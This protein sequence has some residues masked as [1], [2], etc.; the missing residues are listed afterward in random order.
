M[1]YLPIA[2]AIFLGLLSR[3]NCYVVLYF[4]TRRPAFHHADFNTELGLG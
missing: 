4:E 3:C 1:W 2:L